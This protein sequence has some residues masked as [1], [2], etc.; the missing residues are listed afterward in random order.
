VGE[1]QVN[2]KSKTFG[3]RG[4]SA[5][6]NPTHV[7]TSPTWRPRLSVADLRTLRRGWVLLLYHA[8]KPY[9]LRAPI[10]QHRRLFRRALLPW[11]A[12]EPMP[13]HPPVLE[14]VSGSR[15]D[16]DQEFGA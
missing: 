4:G 12:P 8:R 14:V 16:D 9:C 1:R 7:T 3:M 10:A 6:W 13:L 15:G 11:V 5:A 2:T